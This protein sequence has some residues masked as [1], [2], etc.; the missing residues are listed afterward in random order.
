M[1]RAWPTAHALLAVSISSRAIAE[2]TNVAPDSDELPMTWVMKTHVEETETVS[3]TTP[4]KK[5]IITGI[6][7]FGGSYLPA[8]TVAITSPRDADKRMVVPIF[9]PWLSLADPGEC[10]AAVGRPCTREGAYRVLIVADGL[11]QA[12]GAF[13]FAAAFLYPD[14][15][16]VT[17]PLFASTTRMHVTPAMVGT[18]Y[19]FFARGVF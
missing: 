18:G 19:G 15:V 10:G 17:R 11:L 7:V 5:L 4:S 8:L 14:T 13:A 9:G 3:K 12:G 1:H 2:E 6:T 16:T